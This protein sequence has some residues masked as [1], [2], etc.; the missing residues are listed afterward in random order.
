MSN[1]RG[2]LSGIA[3]LGGALI[4]ANIHVSTSRAMGLG[5][6]RAEFLESPFSLVFWIVA[7]L[8]FALFF[9]A[10]RLHSKGLRILLFWTP[11]VV[12]SALGVIF[13]VYTYIWI[14]YRAA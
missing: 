10:S 2:F 6:A 12:I 11:V 5:A 13:G 8:L 14:H 4:G 3:A 9:A 7:V 1:L